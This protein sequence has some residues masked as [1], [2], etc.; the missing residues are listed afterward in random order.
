MELDRLFPSLSYDHE[1][2]L[3]IYVVHKGRLGSSPPA[4]PHQ[5]SFFKLIE[6][7]KTLL[8]FKK[9]VCCITGGP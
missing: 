9:R 1:I 5:Y 7:S 6:S 3:Y 2:K 4:P 8:P